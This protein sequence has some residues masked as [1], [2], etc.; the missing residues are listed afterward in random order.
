[1]RGTITFQ[2]VARM[3]KKKGKKQDTS[4]SEDEGAKSD[5]E[6]ADAMA[7]ASLDPKYPVQ[8]LYC[9]ACSCPPEY[10]G[11]TGAKVGTIDEACKTWLLANAP[12]MA[13]K[14][15][16][17]G[18]DGEA[19]AA[20]GD[21][22]GKPMPG[23]KKK[24]DAVKEVLVSSKQRQKKKYVCTVRGLEGFGVKLPDACKV[25]KKKFSTG[26]SVTETPD[27]KEEIEIQGDVK[28]DVVPLIV[29]EFGIDI[30]DIFF[31]EGTGLKIS[32]TPAS[33]ILEGDMKVGR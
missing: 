12:V 32:K 11:W 14:F 3:P 19:A 23:G 18:A 2:R 16:Y 10:C 24:K 25:F 9:G 1:M 15:G 17:D 13:A 33:N 20:G 28:D 29:K 8:I 30:K 6:V 7:N 27:Q 26:A 5:G 21:G 22:E 31:L 4:G